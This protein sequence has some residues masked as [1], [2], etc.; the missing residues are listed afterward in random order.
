MLVMTGLC[1][2]AAAAPRSGERAG[3]RSMEE[4]ARSNG[5]FPGALRA[6]GG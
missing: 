6:P 5:S 4:Y 2:V 3:N 1:G